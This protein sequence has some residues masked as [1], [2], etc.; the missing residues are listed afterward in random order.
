[1]KTIIN[2][3]DPQNEFHVRWLNLLSDTAQNMEKARLDQFC[4]NNP[5]DVKLNPLDI[6]QVHFCLALKYTEA[7]FKKQAWIPK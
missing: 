4:D 3:F 5:W 7:I 2:N 6:P 1:M